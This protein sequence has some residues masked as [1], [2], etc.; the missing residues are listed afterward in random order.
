M[1]DL[2]TS[3]SV[4][5]TPPVSRVLDSRRKVVKPALKSSPGPSS[6]TTLKFDTTLS[7]GND[8]SF[9]A[10]SLIVKPSLETLASLKRILKKT[11]DVIKALSPAVLFSD[12]DDKQT[13]STVDMT[14]ELNFIYS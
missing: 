7:V 9:E 4:P 13:V 1:A 12:K 14:D 5:T 11:H 2:P 6:S 10:S 8:S 3:S